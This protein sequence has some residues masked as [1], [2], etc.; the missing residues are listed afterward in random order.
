[1]IVSSSLKNWT[2]HCNIHKKIQNQRCTRFNNYYK[3]TYNTFCSFM[4]K[5]LLWV[6]DKIE[7]IK[8]KITSE[9]SKM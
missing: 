3:Q 7:I 9:N 6:K 5:F 4:Y 1:M 2:V 8:I